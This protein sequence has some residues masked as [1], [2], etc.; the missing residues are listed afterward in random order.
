MERNHYVSLA[1]GILLIELEAKRIPDNT[2]EVPS[3]GHFQTFLYHLTWYSLLFQIVN[4][5]FIVTFSFPAKRFDYIF[6]AC[7]MSSLLVYVFVEYINRCFVGVA[8]YADECY[9]PIGSR[10]ELN[11]FPSECVSEWVW[12][13]SH[14]VAVLLCVGLMCGIHMYTPKTPAPV[15]TG[16]IQ[17]VRRRRT[18]PPPR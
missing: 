2:P 17:T 3:M 18:V 5:I 9:S 7:G 6:A 13:C 16:N 8:E 1:A 4:H 12:F 11:I 15:I 14:I 10:S